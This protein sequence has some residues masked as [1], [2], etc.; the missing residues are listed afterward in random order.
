MEGQPDFRELF[1]LLNRH[2]AEFVIVGAYALAF[3]GIPRNTG[4][5]DVYIRPNLDNAERILEA[6]RDFGF[7]SLQL[8]KEDFQQPGQVIQLGAPP[9]RVDFLTSISGVTWE[10]A[11]KGKAVGH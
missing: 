3:H 5:I 1:T 8:T 9:V 6:L 4:D 2:K 10:Q 11:D 7:S